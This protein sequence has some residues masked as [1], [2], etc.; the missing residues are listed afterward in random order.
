[1]THYLFDVDGTITPSRKPM[2]KTF[3]P[4]FLKFSLENEVSLVSGSNFEKLVEQLDSEILKSVKYTF[5][6]SGNHVKFLGKTIYKNIFE[7][8]EEVYEW[9]NKALSYSHFPLRTGNHI[10]RRIGSINFSI[11]GRNANSD[12]RQIYVDWDKQFNER[13]YLSQTFNKLFPKY[14]ATIGGE[15]GLD[16]TKNKLDKRQVVTWLDKES[17]LIFVGDKCEY[18]GN[19][20]PLAQAIYRRRNGQYFNVFDWHETKILLDNWST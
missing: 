18:G 10:E 1:M 13:V 20:Y 8:S 15:T 9:L 6:C 19:D 5:C 17:F 11:V 2:D 3:V 12:E 16:I 7:F 14:T 4:E